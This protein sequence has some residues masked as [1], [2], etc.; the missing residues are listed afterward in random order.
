[1]KSTGWCYFIRSGDY[2]KV[3]VTCRASLVERLKSY[4]THN[5]HGIELIE[6]IFCEE[7]VEMEEIL[8]EKYFKKTAESDWEKL[9]EKE[10]KEISKLFK[11]VSQK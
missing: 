6:S 10:I 1:M 4:R 8:L 3:G 11:E 2:F 9:S 5:P 7:Y